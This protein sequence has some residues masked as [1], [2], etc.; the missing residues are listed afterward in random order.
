M[1]VYALAD[2]EPQ[3]HADAYVHPDATVIG[4][5]TIG[6]GLD[7]LAA[8]GAAGRLRVHH[9]GRA[10]VGPGRHR[11]ALHAAVPDDHR[12]RLRD[13]PSRA[14]RVLHHP[15]RLA[16]RH[17]ID[18]VAPRRRRVRGARGSGRGGAQRHG[19]AVTRAWRSA[20]PRSSAPIRSTTRRSSASSGSTWRT[21]CAT[22]PS[23]A[24][25]TD[26]AAATSGASCSPGANGREPGIPAR[27]ERRV[28]RPSP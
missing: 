6:R 12:Q 4:N 22:A 1:A 3:I 17:G 25:S 7:G 2:V 10:H 13:R 28:D 5:V 26:P 11:G 16:R 9:R 24:A 21:R 8:H 27:S 19:R 18:R 14:P 20:F 15:R 23:S